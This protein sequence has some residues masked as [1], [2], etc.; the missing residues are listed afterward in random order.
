MNYSAVISMCFI[1]N[2]STVISPEVSDLQ[3][4][5]KN[6]SIFV[7]L[8]SYRTEIA[9]DCAALAYQKSR[10]KLPQKSRLYKLETLAS[11][12]SRVFSKSR[13]IFR[14]VALVTEPNYRP[15]DRAGK[16]AKPNPGFFR[17]AKN[18]FPRQKE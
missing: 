5:D 7:I 3:L 4:Y 18:N 1:R 16:W 10:Q 11:V 14:A 6:N 2:F 8:H 12:T 17:S 9:P 13:L 15:C